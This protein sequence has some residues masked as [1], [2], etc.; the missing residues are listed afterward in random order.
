M[1]ALSFAVMLLPNHSC[2][3]SWTMMKSH[4]S[5]SPVPEPSRKRYPFW[6]QLPYDTALWCSIPVF[7][8]SISL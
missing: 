2:A 1:S 6:N 4:V 5:P 7:G 3:L 8:T